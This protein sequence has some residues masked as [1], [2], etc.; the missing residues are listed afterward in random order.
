MSTNVVPSEAALYYPFH[1]CAESTLTAL[2]RQ[3]TSVHF[4]DYMA[5]QLTRFSGTTAYRDRIGAGHPDLVASGRIVQGHSVSGPLPSDVESAVDRD[6]AD[7]RWRAHFH[8]SLTN[9]KRVQRGLF[10]PAHAMTI[11]GTVVPG[12]AFLRELLRDEYRRTPFTVDAVRAMS[13]T[14]QRLPAAFAYEYGL[15]LVKTSASLV[16]TARLAAQLHCTA[17]TD[18]PAHARLF[19]HS[20]AREGWQVPQLLLDRAT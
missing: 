8:D 16:Y 4:R 19:A 5:L 10:D 11:G 17:V 12:A 6:L 13:A 1:L 14:A 18:S 15:A 9:D 7:D 2:L 20:Q 3:F